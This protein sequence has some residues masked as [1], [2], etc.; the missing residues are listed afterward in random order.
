MKI[1]RFLLVAVVGVALMGASSAIAGQS[2]AGINNPVAGEVPKEGKKKECPKGKKKECPK[3]KK[4][5]CPK[6]KKKD[7]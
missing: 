4:K 7:A 6:G 2:A 5:E 1:F 3:G